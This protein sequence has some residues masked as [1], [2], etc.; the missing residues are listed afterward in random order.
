MDKPLPDKDKT[1]DREENTPDATGTAVQK[2]GNDYNPQLTEE[3]LAKKTALKDTP[4]GRAAIRIFSR[5]LLGTTA[6]AIGGIY[7]GRTMSGYTPH[8]PV[9]NWV[10]GIAKFYDVVFGKPLKATANFLGRDGEKFVNNFR[11]TVPFYKDTGKF[12]RSLGHEVV[13]VTFDFASMS[14]GDFWG[15]KIAQTVDPNGEPV[16]WK[17][18]DGSVD[19]NE[20]VKTFG[21]NWWTALT[22]SAGEDW[23]VAVPYVLSMRHI[24]T[25]LV[26]KMIPGYRHDFDLTGSGG[27]LKINSQGK[28]TGNFTTAGVINLWERFTT[29][30]VGTLLFR[31][32]YHYTGNRVKHAWQTGEIPALIDQ[33]PDHPQRSAPEKL[34]AA[35]KQFVN[36]GA[37]GTVK[38]LT[39]M[40][41]AVP[42]FWVTRVPQNKFRGAFIHP[43]KGALIYEKY[44]DEKGVVWHA[45]H[46]NTL[47]RPDHP[48]ARFGD[49]K[50]TKDTPVYFL[51]GLDKEGKYIVERAVNPFKDGPIDPHAKTWGVVD[52][53][54][55]PVAKAADKT[56]EV[57][58]KP[59]GH[60]FNALGVVSDKIRDVIGRP[61]KHKY[62]PGEEGRLRAGTYLMASMSYT[63]YF[64]AKSDWLAD[65]WDYGR[66]DVAVDRTLAGAAHLKPGEFKA[67]LGEMWQALK[68]QPLKDP[69]R[70][71]YA[72]CREATDE[73]PSD[74]KFDVNT[75]IGESCD[76]ILKK[77][78]PEHEL[79]WQERT[80]SGKKPEIAAHENNPKGHAEREEMRKALEELQPPTNSI[81]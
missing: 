55:N 15:R 56:R 70:E 6:F 16:K 36:W 65:K 25:P 53:A 78:P 14:V 47:M 71:K 19:W 42:F 67:G 24:T 39:Y 79:T 61:L 64:W 54:L 33:D 31:E 74:N 21:H 75:T 11:P 59:F 45:V 68:R 58:R 9:K 38:A 2:S 20:A 80:I 40:I 57:L 30:N 8:G 60:M 35:T 13:M 37:R 73:S 4:Q 69:V 3:A 66:M 18:K 63:P 29:Y 50:F 10:Q 32:A 81:N 41:P 7:A 12:G 52:A 77:K 34:W 49:E 48:K 1:P 23:A 28:I 51:K 46:A 17:R 27:G 62:S 5:G 26:D 43:E 44:H 76:A 22:Y 72:Q